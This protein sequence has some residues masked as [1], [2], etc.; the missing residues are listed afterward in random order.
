MSSSSSSLSIQSSITTPAGVTHSTGVRLKRFAQRRYTINGVDGFRFKVMAYDAYNMPN[1]IFRYL[2]KPAQP[3]GMEED[4]FNGVCSSVDL[5]EYAQDEPT[6]GQ[7]P[8]F[9]RDHVVDLVF[10]SVHEADTAWEVI[11]QSVATLVNTL[12]FMEDLAEEEEITFGAPLPDD[13]LSSSVGP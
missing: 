7:V 13:G 4:V 1:H 11:Q 6:A 5:S 12:V 9:F 8:K 10:R 3:A 2:R